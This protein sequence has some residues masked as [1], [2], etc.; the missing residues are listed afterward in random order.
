M[1]SPFAVTLIVGHPQR[2]LQIILR[3]YAC[4]ADVIFN[5]DIDSCQ[6]AYDGNTVWATPS[7]RR[8][9]MTGINYVD[10]EQ[11]GKD[12]ETRLA[13]YAGRGFLAAVPGLDLEKVKESYL[14]DG[15]YTV[16]K[17]EKD[18][19]QVFLKFQ[20]DQDLPS[21][22]LRPSPITGLPKL[23]VLS[24]LNQSDM[25]GVQIAQDD[26]VPVEWQRT[27]HQLD[28]PEHDLLGDFQSPGSST[29]YLIDIAKFHETQF[30]KMHGTH[31]K[32]VWSLPTPPNVPPN[33]FLAELE[34]GAQPTDSGGGPL[35]PFHQGVKPAGIYLSNLEGNRGSLIRA[36][37]SV[38]YNFIGDCRLG[39]DCPRVEDAKV[40]Y[41]HMHFEAAGM[42]LQR[43]LRF[44]ASNDPEINPFLWSPESDWTSDAY[45]KQEVE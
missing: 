38:C 24:N 1:R 4:I 15:V 42:S 34:N 27:R 22:T 3:R 18:L 44:P 23:L 32:R 11:S 8:A 29:C 2:H 41:P 13:K 37:R 6:L 35:L 30:I 45:D 39:I 12:F 5:F 33:C 20:H 17:G 43:F 10:P 7:A 36:S 9:L 19:R 25:Y 21:Y 16:V 40:Q 31:N 26:T 14:R 28:R